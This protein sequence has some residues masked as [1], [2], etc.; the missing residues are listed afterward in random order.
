MARGSERCET[1]IARSFF[2]FANTASADIPHKHPNLPT[3]WSQ[4]LGVKT[5][6]C[7][8]ARPCGGP[9][10]GAKYAVL[11]QMRLFFAPA[12]KRPGRQ[13]G[14]ADGLRLNRK[15]QFFPIVNATTSG[16]GVQM[17]FTGNLGG[18]PND[19]LR[20][21]AATAQTTHPMAGS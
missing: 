6:F 21:I 8:P 10:I 2:H 19:K 1:A 15:V 9:R 18:S 4:N 14:V 17:R 13:C 12:L 16:G 3:R 5:G 20:E 7:A 11:V